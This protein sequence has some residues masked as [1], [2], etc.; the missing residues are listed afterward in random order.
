ME[1]ILHQEHSLHAVIVCK[2]GTL[3]D[4]IM[5]ALD[6]LVQVRGWTKD[7]IFDP[8]LP[9]DDSVKAKL[10][11]QFVE[12]ITIHSHGHVPNNFQD[13]VQNTALLLAGLAEPGALDLYFPDAA[14]PVGRHYIV[15]Y[16]TPA[17]IKQAK[18]VAAILSVQGT[19]LAAGVGGEIVAGLNAIGRLF[20][21]AGTSQVPAAMAGG[22]NDLSALI[23]AMAFVFGEQNIEVRKLNRQGIARGGYEPIYGEAVTVARENGAVYAVKVP[24]TRGAW[25]CFNE[26][27]KLVSHLVPQVVGLKFIPAGT[28]D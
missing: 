6:P 20:N 13:A 19:L 27:G 23:A 3:P 22:I 16:G 28:F 1:N 18:Q 7:Q 14:D 11:G 9:M 15:W 5:A 2:P 26:A 17:E 21:A 24:C 8:T 4:A 12:R 10:A 25:Y